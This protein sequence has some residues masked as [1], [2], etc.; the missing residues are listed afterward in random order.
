MKVIFPFSYY[1]PEQCAGISVVDDVM[2]R[3]ADEGDESKLYVP[4]PTRN[5]RQDVEWKRHEFI[6]SECIKRER[7]LF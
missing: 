4:T 6:A 3:L 7:I 1:Y 2:H 5:V